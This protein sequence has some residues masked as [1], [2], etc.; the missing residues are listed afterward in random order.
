MLAF[1]RPNALLILILLVSSMELWQRWKTR[2]H[3]E[4]AGY[5]KVA[6]RRRLG[7]AFAYFAL[8]AL[9]VVGMHYTHVPRDF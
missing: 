6:P 2:G 3:P 1:L 9:L 4:N 8:A 7:I 5:Y